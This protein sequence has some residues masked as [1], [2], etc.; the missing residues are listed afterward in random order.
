M[1]RLFERAPYVKCRKMFDEQLDP[2]R[3]V[4]VAAEV[5]LIFIGPAQHRQQALEGRK[6]T[7][8]HGR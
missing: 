6:L 2:S 8:V 4:S 3:W 7:V 5:R 1:N